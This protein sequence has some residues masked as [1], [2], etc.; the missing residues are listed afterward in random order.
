M[1][2]YVIANGELYHWGVKGM[3]WGVR[4]KKRP[5]SPDYEKAHSRK[6][7]SE[8]DTQELRERNNR[9]QAEQQYIEL[10]R[11]SSK[12]QRAATAFIKTAGTIAGVAGAYAIYKKYGTQA[13]DAIGNW[14]VNGAIGNWVVNGIDLSGPL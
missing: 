8:M 4:R 10:R 7:I 1:S 14:A 9:L 11:Q 3:K 12:G 5:V 13:V 6:R 2:N